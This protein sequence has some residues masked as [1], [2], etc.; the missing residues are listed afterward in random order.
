GR[1]WLGFVGF[2]PRNLARK[3]RHHKHSGLSWPKVVEWAHPQDR[4][5]VS[6]EIL[7]AKEG[8]CGF[9]DRVGVHGS[10]KALLADR[11][12]FGS[13]HAVLLAGAYQYNARRQLLGTQRFK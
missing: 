7:I 3:V 9:R 10:Q 4:Q 5:L 8:L 11:V 2:D 1:Y 13:Y 12:L 6:E